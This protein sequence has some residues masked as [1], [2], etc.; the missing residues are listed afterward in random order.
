MKRSFLFVYGTLRRDF[1]NYIS[2]LLAKNAD[3]ISAATYQGKLYLIDDYP[4]VVPSD[5]PTDIVR[6]EVY[7][8]NDPDHLLSRLDEYEECGLGFPKPKEYVRTLQSVRLNN[9]EN[10][11]AWI[12]LYQWSTEKLLLLPS[13]D[14]LLTIKRN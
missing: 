4:G 6:G 11:F 8:L 5:M 9:G 2:D 14:F 7:Q 12:Y 1:C 13:G 3:L 10:I